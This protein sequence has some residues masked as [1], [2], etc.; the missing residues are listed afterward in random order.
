[1]ARGKEEAFVIV[2]IP[3]PVNPAVSEWMAK[4]GSKGGKV[5]SPLKGFG[6]TP[7]I[8]QPGCRCNQ[9]KKCKNRLAQ[10]RFRERQ[11]QLAS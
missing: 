2:W 9:C 5:S 10:Q 11:A 4:V 1:M 7:Y 8:R 6:T 3:D